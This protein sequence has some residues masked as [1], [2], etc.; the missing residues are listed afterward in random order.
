[1]KS[2]SDYTKTKHF[3][4]ADGTMCAENQTDRDERIACDGDI[5]DCVDIGIDGDINVHFSDYVYRRYDYIEFNNGER[6]GGYPYRNFSTISHKVKQKINRLT[7][8][9][10]KKWNFFIFTGDNMASF[11][12]QVQ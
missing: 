2:C 4:C 8:N 10:S 1:M 12:C 9:M 11:V 6:Y 7:F 5:R 3:N